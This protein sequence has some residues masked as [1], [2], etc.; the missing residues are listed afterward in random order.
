MAER[1]LRQTSVTR[2]VLDQQDIHA[3]SAVKTAVLSVS[4]CSDRFDY[5]QQMLARCVLKSEL[6][7]NLGSFMLDR[8]NRPLPSRCR[9][10]ADAVEKGKNELPEIFPCAPV[11]TGIS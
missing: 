3:L 8:L 6:Y 2:I 1:L 5:G 7:V 4:I 10:L 11:K 9:L